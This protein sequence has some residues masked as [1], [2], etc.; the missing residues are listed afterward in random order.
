METIQDLTPTGQIAVIDRA[1]DNFDPILLSKIL[2]LELRN[3]NIGMVKGKKWIAKAF[4]IF[5]EELEG[6]Y[7]TFEDIGTATQYLESDKEKDQDYTLKQI[8]TLLE[9][10]CMGHADSFLVIKDILLSLSSLERKWFVRYWLRNPNNGI[11]L[12]QVT[13]SI[14][15]HYSKPVSV[16]KKDMSMNSIEVVLTF[17]EKGEKPPLNLT[18]G[19]FVKPML[20]K[21]VPMDKWPDERIVDYKYDGN[22]YQIHLNY[23]IV[24]PS[25][26]IFNRSGKVVTSQFPDVVKQVTGYNRENGYPTG[27]NCILDGEI[28]PINS[29]GSPAP[30]KLMATRVHSKNKEEAVRKVAVKWV[31]FDCLKF[32]N[33]VI[34]D[35]PYKERLEVFKDLP[36]QAH[37]M[38]EGSNT[39]AF[40]N[41]AISD[42]FEGIIVKDANMKYEPAKRSAGWA[43]Y[44]PPRIE[45]DVVILGACYGENSKSSVFSSFDIAVKDGDGFVSL[46]RVGNGFTDA[47]LVSLTSTLR[48]IVDGHENNMY[49]FL[50]R[51]VITVTADLVS[52]NKDGSLGLRF[53]RKTRLRDD[54][55]VQ[56][57]DTLETVEKLIFG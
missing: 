1:W 57:I 50:P 35:L 9:Y 33:K 17:Y 31:I 51:K 48:K 7:S 28:Y 8:I 27:F 20:A 19:N 3:N 6:L 13:K 30:H 37:R 4:D 5:D 52:Q 56:D 53:P 11:G 16:V 54:K 25:V 55:Y 44:K 32:D 15:S 43:K 12:G 42:G 34:M 46:G 49:R 18:H 2:T 41:Q 36:D 22:R 47:E 10:D 26:I 21:E 39:M 45:L 23:T 14:A 40:Y 38:P 29:D 24:G